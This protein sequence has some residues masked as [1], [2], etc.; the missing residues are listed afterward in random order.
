MTPREV[1]V[2]AR[3]LIEK[4]EQW[5]Q[6]WFAKTVS[7]EEVASLDPRACRWCLE[8]ACR[9]ASGFVGDTYGDEFRPI[10]RLLTD[11]IGGRHPQDFNDSSITTHAQVLAALDRAIEAAP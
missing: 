5:T 9:R 7:G 6:G 2:A 3:K 8:G 11:A 1:L 4:P 10:R